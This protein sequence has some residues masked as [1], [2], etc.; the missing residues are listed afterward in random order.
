MFFSDIVGFT[1]IADRVE[2]EV[3]TQV[4]NE[5]LSS[6]SKTV[7]ASGGTLNE[8]SGDG[9][10][11]LFGAPEAMEPREQVRCAVDM[12]LAMQRD[13]ARLN[14]SWRE[15]GLGE[16]L[17]VRMGIN[18]GMLSVGSFGSQG[19]MTYTA[20]GL[21]TNVTNRIQAQCQPGGILLSDASWQL[22][23]DEYPCTSKG[24][25]EVKGVHFPIKVYEVDSR[26]A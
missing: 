2:P 8:I 10:M 9:I 24:E 20:I 16:K 3:I 5:Y 21:Q 7:N 6:M 22:V 15:L 11:A 12:A 26:I 17:R 19:R 23:R 13:M 14:E 4:L 25:I 18:T 1:D